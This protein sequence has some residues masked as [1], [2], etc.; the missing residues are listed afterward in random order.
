MS[1]DTFTGGE[2]DADDPYQFETVVLRRP[3]TAE[4]RQ[5]SELLDTYVMPAA[6]L[7]GAGA[8]VCA[9]RHT[10]YGTATRRLRDCVQAS[11]QLRSHSG[12]ITFTFAG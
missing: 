9:L 4:Q 2:T 10:P 11:R 7:K 6:L 8:G 12:C 5:L 3:D 1:S